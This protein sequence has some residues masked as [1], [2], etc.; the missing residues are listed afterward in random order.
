[1]ILAGIDE[2]GYGPVLGPLV[3][4][5]CAFHIEDPAGEAMPCLWTRLKRSVS[6][7]KS[8]GGKKLHVNDSKAVYTP[9]AGLKELERSVLALAGTLHGNCGDL[10]ALLTRTSPDVIA[11]LAGYSWYRSEAGEKFPLSQA[12]D[13]I[14]IWTNSLAVEMRQSKVA[15]VHLAARVL[16]EKQLNAM[17]EATRNKASALFSITAVHLDH[18][19]RAYGEK[20]LTI[21]CDRQGGR[22]RYGSLLRLMFEDWALEVTDETEARSEYHLRR[23][24]HAVRLIFCEKAEAQCLPVAAASMLCK[25]LREALMTRFNAY[26]LRHVPLTAPT[27]G[28]YTDGLRFL[29]D[30]EPKR[31]ELGVKD[32]ELIRCR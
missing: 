16:C 27:A 23:N 21:V 24:G 3:V 17:M 4:G 19:L 1:M 5:C 10:D 22:S 20:Q 29:R 12:A 26:W 15:C 9:A 25:Y 6:K 13:S 11:D 28:Y 18:L 30:I 7:R 2:A 31:K 8:A 14:G 32:G